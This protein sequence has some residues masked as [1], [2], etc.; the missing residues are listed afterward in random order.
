MSI[1]APP[2]CDCPGF[3]ESCFGVVP[4][5]GG[6]TSGTYLE[7]PV[8]QGQETLPGL[9]VIGETD[10]NTLFASG[11][12][13]FSKNIIMDGVAGVNYIEFP[14]GTKQYTACE[15][16][17]TPTVI[18][19]TDPT[20]LTANAFN[21]PVIIPY[22]S[23]ANYTSIYAFS[24][25]AGLQ[26]YDVTGN[27][28]PGSS[29]A[30]ALQGTGTSGGGIYLASVP[31]SIQTANAY[32]VALQLN[33]YNYNIAASYVGTAL[34]SMTSG[35]GTITFQTP[36]S[37]TF[38]GITAG[39]SVITTPKL[40]TATTYV[41]TATSSTAT[42]PVTTGGT[43]VNYASQA[44]AIPVSVYANLKWTGQSS[45]VNGQWTWISGANPPLGYPPYIIITPTW[46]CIISY[47]FGTATGPMITYGVPA[48][49]NYAAA[50]SY[51]YPLLSGV[52]TVVNTYTGANYVNSAVIR[53]AVTNPTPS[54]GG[55]QAG[56]TGGT[57][58]TGSSAGG[59]LT[60]YPHIAGSV[61]YG[62]STTSFPTGISNYTNPT[63]SNAGAA[64]IATNP[65]GNTAVASC[66]NNGIL[67][68]QLDTP[69]INVYGTPGLGGFLMLNG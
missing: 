48:T 46:S 40:A 4:S 69:F 5:T 55:T 2:T 44:T 7:F 22:S 64:A 61:G 38:A 34:I 63:V 28:T 49:A 8:G 30:I 15:P 25:G 37:G 11:N 60:T 16:T 27:E 24:G 9:V 56:K 12:A 58:T 13:T 65:S 32:L 19:P 17:G 43:S 20:T 41:I 10:V 67:T 35:S 53:G 14:D 18:I 26:L 6:G 3:N 54:K 50:T 36:T 57:I 29:F 66:A 52:D 47:P 51:A 59:T 39:S 45:I 23:G 68:Y 62:A 21:N 33:T 1:K 31:T 42:Y